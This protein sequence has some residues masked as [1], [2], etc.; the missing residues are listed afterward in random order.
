MPYVGR[1]GE[2]MAWALNW[3]GL[4][5]DGWI[6][7]DLGSH[8]GGFVDALLQAGAARVHAVDVCYGTF[9]W[10]LRR[11][12]RV[13]LHERT[14]ALHVELPEKVN[15]LTSDVGWTRQDKILPRAVSLLAPGGFVLSLLKPQYEA[16]KDEM[17]K[18][19]GRVLDSALERILPRIR[20]TALALGLPVKGPDATPFLG[21]KG[22]NPEYFLLLGPKQDVTA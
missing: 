12:P 21:G 15:L 11:D 8:V 22:K 10:K 5:P 18:G 13:V 6:C 9:A 4:K 3:A 20:Q 1:G 14:N 7:C 16:E 19:R 17:Q 2:K